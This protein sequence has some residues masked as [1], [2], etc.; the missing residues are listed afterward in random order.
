MSIKGIVSLR[1]THKSEKALKSHK[2]KI[3]KRGGKIE[4]TKKTKQGYVLDYQFKIYK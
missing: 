2:S 4:G 1:K 3:V